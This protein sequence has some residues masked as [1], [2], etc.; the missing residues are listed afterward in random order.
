MRFS[1]KSVTFLAGVLTA[2]SL[3]VSLLPV[4]SS[5][6][7]SSTTIIL[8]SGS[9]WTVPS[10]WNSADNSIEVIGG[11]AAGGSGYPNSF[12]GGGGAYAKVTNI[13][14]TPGAAVGYHVGAGGSS[15]GN[16]GDTYFCTGATG[17]SSIGGAAVVVGAKGGVAGK[18]GTILDTE[19]ISAGA[20]TPGVGGAASASIGSVKYSGG[21][22]ATA[23]GEC[24]SGGGGAA[25]P[26]GNGAN[27]GTCV[28]GTS[29][30]GGGGANGGS[31]GKANSSAT[32]GAGGNGYNGTGGG[33]AGSG[34]GSNGGGGGGALRVSF[35]QTPLPGGTG[36][37]DSIW[38]QT[39]GGAL[40]GPGGGGG[41]SASGGT[42]G[43]GGGYGAGGGG[44]HG[45]ES[46]SGTQGVIVITYRNSVSAPPAAGP[47]CSITFDQNPATASAGT[48]IHWTSTG[49]NDWMYINNIGYVLGS[50]SAHVQP[51]QTTSYSG[52]VG[53]TETTQTSGTSSDSPTSQIYA[54]PGTYTFTVPSYETLTVEVWGGGGGG[55]GAPYD[56]AAGH[57]GGASSWD[58]T[59]AA[60]GGA[61]G[62]AN[63]TPG[64]AGGSGSGGTTNLTG[65]KGE[66]GVN[67]SYGG[68]GG[69]GANGGAG[70]ARTN[71]GSSP[72]IVN[73]HPGTA[74]GGG[75]SGAVYSTA[76]VSHSGAGAGG[77]GYAS[78]AYTAGAYASGSTITVV[79]GAG[80]AGGYYNASAGGNGAPG[81]VKITW[82]ADG[83]GS[84]GSSLPTST[85]IT[86]ATCPATLT[87]DN[88]A[89]CPAGQ[90]LSGN[91]C[92]CDG[93]D[94]IPVNG[95][96]V[97]CAAGET[98]NGTQCVAACPVGYTL[99][100]GVCTYIGCPA[101]YTLQGTVCVS[102][103]QCPAFYCV[104]DDLYQNDAQCNSSFLQHCTYGCLNGACLPPPRGTGDLRAVPT[105]VRSGETSRVSW[106]TTNM[107]SNSCT[108]TSSLA[109]STV[110]SRALTGS[111]VSAPITQR[112]TYTLNCTDLAGDSFTDSAI[113]NLLPF[114]Q[115]I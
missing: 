30:P 79:V 98:W 42:G 62:P 106:T 111:F 2:G 54:T 18:P 19:P 95:Q 61:G 5:A 112:T 28:A 78:R 52:E 47:S 56:A 45:T 13:S 69:A 41:G 113:I 49:D 101:G 50:G 21:S 16:G 63:Y 22:G 76:R 58:G 67:F 77:G 44:S 109:P 114:F 81:Q 34:T 105:L 15:E 71:R 66:A 35:G 53:H 25:G 65:G 108:V 55:T 20:G 23:N 74:P 72:G 94:L 32:P 3:A 12:G 99:Q 90:H 115:E 43:A 11:G 59:L 97:V 104:G 10:D 82:T 83:S 1:I 89:Q 9:S 73:G 27:G 87:I 29:G 6:Q 48:T 51:S 92:L 70:G 110:L 107:R 36:G 80:G 38:Q 60:A 37:Q 46:A 103:P 102:G 26:N 8:T 86:D 31:T 88:T 84:S 64:G 93:T 40:A 91:A 57:S 85:E 75:G 24:G 96:C 4:Y 17:C 39:A 33:V 68:A 7:T 100:G 14:L